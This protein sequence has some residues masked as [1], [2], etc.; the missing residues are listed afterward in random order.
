MEYIGAMTATAT[1]PTPPPRKRISS[2]SMTEE[3]LLTVAVHLL[4]VEDGDVGEQ[5]VNRA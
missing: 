3:R 2:G 4:L 5:G 1:T